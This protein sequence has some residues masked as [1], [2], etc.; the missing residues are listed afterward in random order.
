V[1]VSL[2]QMQA[3]LEWVAIN[4]PRGR[5]WWEF[6]SFLIQKYGNKIVD[7]KISG[8]INITE[9]EIWQK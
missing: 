2:K 5:D 7:T 6:I 4:S 1:L 8:D 9:E 3:T